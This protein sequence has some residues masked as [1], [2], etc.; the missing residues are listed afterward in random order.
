PVK[1]G[2]SAKSFNRG[3]TVTYQQ[4]PDS[5]SEGLAE[6]IGHLVGDGCMTD[7]QTQWVYGGDDVDDGLAD[8]HQGLLRELIGGISRQPMPNGTVQLRAGSEAVREFFR[9]LG[10]TTARAH[11][12]RV[13][14]AIFKAPVETQASFLR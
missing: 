14:A 10:V 12:K 7:A 5:W 4:L 13:P 11:E 1:V 3:G 8:S 9:S 6:L 2:A